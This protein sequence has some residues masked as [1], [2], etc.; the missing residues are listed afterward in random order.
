MSSFIRPI[1]MRTTGIVRRLSAAVAIGALAG[2]PL[3]IPASAVDPASVTFTGGGI[4]LPLCESRPDGSRISVPGEKKVRLTS[5][6]G[7]DAR[8]AHTAASSRTKPSTGT[9]PAGGGP[10]RNAKDGTPPV[11]GASGATP[12]SD[13]VM[14]GVEHSPGAILESPVTVV[15]PGRSP[16][17]QGLA[18][19]TG[20]VDKGSMG[21]L[22][23]IATVCVVGVSAGAIR[24][25]IT[26]RATRTGFA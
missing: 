20:P 8:N 3:A 10:A 9:A 6:L 24:A 5:R 19:D 22:A 26:Q 17:G 18:G 25:I 23:I 2:L 1:R 12:F 13:P 4:R 11:P 14:P 15:H 16:R 21:L 7:I